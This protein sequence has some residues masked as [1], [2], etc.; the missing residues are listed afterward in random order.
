MW[1]NIEWLSDV[2]ETIITKSLCDF[3]TVRATYSGIFFG[4]LFALISR[5]QEFPKELFLRPPM[6]FNLLYADFSFHLLLSALFF[7]SLLESLYLWN[8]SCFSIR[9]QGLAL[10]GTRQ[11]KEKLHKHNMTIYFENYQT[12]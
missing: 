10:Q 7:L 4:V 2:S 12:P 3:L 1:V 5:Y 8:L 6:T 11:A 9:I